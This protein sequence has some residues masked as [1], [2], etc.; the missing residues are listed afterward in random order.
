VNDT[1]L[2]SVT[3]SPT[4]VTIFPLPRLNPTNASRVDLD[5]GQSVT[6]WSNVTGGAGGDLF[7]WNSLP[8]SCTGTT[9][10]SPTCEPNAPGAYDVSATV[11][12]RNGVTSPESSGVNLIVYGALTLESVRAAPAN[13]VLGSRLWINASV[14]GG[15]PNDTF[16]WSKLPPG[17]AGT[18]AQIEC[19][20]TAA[21]TYEVVV[22]VEDGNGAIAK[23]PAVQVVVS[24]GGSPASALSTPPVEWGLVGAAVIIALVV[25]V[26]LKKRGNR[27]RVAPP[28]EHAG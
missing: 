20:P 16:G 14:V 24:T 11:T 23:S 13:V 27:R 6:F 3:S 26:G 21:G 22:V 8:G 2:N 12:D 5:V 15:S 4:S 1:N 10:N 19:L 28:P 25:I 7:I 17:C 18:T 9:T